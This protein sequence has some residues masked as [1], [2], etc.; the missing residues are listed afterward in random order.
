MNIQRH[1]KPQDYSARTKYRP[2]AAW[3]RRLNRIGIPLTSLGLAPHDAV[4]LEVRGRSSGR[5]QRIPILRTRYR[6]ADYLVS[7]SGE[8]QWVRNVR[9]AGGAAT[10][11]R[12][13]AQ[14]VRLVELPTAERP[15]I[16]A[17]YL[18]AGHRRGGEKAAA[19]QAR[20]YFGLPSD[21]TIEEIASV[22]GHY[23]VFRVE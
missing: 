6:G 18:R 23:P 16:I 12:R 13:G 8:A 1:L 21:P 14:R 19:G 4:T 7:L 9:A 22:A 17:E 10:I 3:Y 5:T 11:R 20:Y 2:P 15:E